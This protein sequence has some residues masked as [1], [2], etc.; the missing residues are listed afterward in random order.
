MNAA[1]AAASWED[2]SSDPPESSSGMAPK[3]ERGLEQEVEMVDSQPV[4]EAPAD[5]EVRTELPAAAREGT[6]GM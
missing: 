1:A 6:R 3:M 4:V 5:Q 2:P